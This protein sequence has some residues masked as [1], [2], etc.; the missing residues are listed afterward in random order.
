MS[1]PA[2]KGML[3]ILF[4]FL[5]I[6][7]NFSTIFLFLFWVL[8][9]SVWVHQRRTFV[10][11]SLRFSGRGDRRSD[12]HRGGPEPADEPPPNGPP[13]QHHSTGLCPGPT[14]PRSPLTGSWEPPCP[15][16]N[17]PSAVIYR[18]HWWFMEQ[19]A[20]TEASAPP[21]APHPTCIHAS[22]CVCWGGGGGA[23]IIQYE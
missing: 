3:K 4:M 7:K 16:P 5:P 22:V 23:P 11:R 17:P 10:I 20:H 6:K 1:V 19:S 13:H 8:V 21:H 9:R 15:P 14:Q 12:R 2:V 18:K